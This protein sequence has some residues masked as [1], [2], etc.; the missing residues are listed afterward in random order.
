MP[1]DKMSS[2]FDKKRLPLTV[3]ALLFLGLCLVFWPKTEPNDDVLYADR[4]EARLASMV[5]DLCGVSGSCVLLT[6]ES[7]GESVYTMQN[8]VDTKTP[9]IRG[10]AVI[11]KGGD[12]PSLQKKITDLIA[13]VTG[14]P[15]NRISVCG[16]GKRQ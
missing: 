8:L 11:C 6:T 2:F 15:A 14:A 3:G 10:V 7:L 5:D 9:E 12:S 4:L 16:I 1:F 13:A